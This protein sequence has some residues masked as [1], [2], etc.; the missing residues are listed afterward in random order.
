[1]AHEAF[2]LLGDALWLDFVN[3]ARGPRDRR[4]EHRAR[5]IVREIGA[6]DR[7]GFD[8][9]LLD[10]HARR[11]HVRAAEV[12][13]ADEVGRQATNAFTIFAGPPRTRRIA[14]RSAIAGM[15][16]VSA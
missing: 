11:A 3:T 4:D 16:T 15:T 8:L 6:A 5:C 13:G 2:I 1:M 10:V 7:C 12:D 14:M 9:A